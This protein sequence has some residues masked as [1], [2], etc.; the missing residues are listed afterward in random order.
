VPPDLAETTYGQAVPE[1]LCCQQLSFAR[2]LLDSQCADVD[3]NNVRVQAGLD[4][5]KL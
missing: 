4:I 2:V 3:M 1:K 5:S